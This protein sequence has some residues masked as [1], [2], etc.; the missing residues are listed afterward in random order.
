MAGAPESD[1]SASRPRA[2][3]KGPRAWRGRTNESVG[4]CIRSS[5]R[6]AGVCGD[7]IRVGG[8]AIAMPLARNCMQ[9]P[10]RPQPAASTARRRAR[11]PGEAALA[12]CCRSPGRR[13]FS[14]VQY[15]KAYRP[16]HRA[17]EASPTR[18]RRRWL[19]RRAG[20][21]AAT[22][23]FWIQYELGRS[24]AVQAYSSH[25][26]VRNAGG[27][28]PWPCAWCDAGPARRV[29]LSGARMR[30]KR[31]WLEPSLGGPAVSPG[32][33]LRSTPSS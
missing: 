1:D 22:R 3:S 13:N 31:R 2:A 15:H 23:R 24:F 9:H 20:A 12:V 14:V 5:K 10:R 11:G 6:L 30:R 29:T 28:P 19:R 7:A 25:P 21:A 4:N 16:R 32:E 17:P 8:D 27:G 26:G 18:C 33:S